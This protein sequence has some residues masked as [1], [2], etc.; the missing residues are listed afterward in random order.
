ME[1][2]TSVAIVVTYKSNSK[3]DTMLREQTYWIQ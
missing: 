3:R 1:S 2:V